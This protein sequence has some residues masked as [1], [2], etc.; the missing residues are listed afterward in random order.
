MRERMIDQDW[1]ALGKLGHFLKGSAA[2]IGLVKL[3]DSCYRIQILGS[4]ADA[5][6]DPQR[7]TLCGL[8]AQ[9]ERE[10]R[11]AQAYFEHIFRQ[12]F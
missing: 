3:S 6:S 9:V 8:V 11:Q 12:T 1:E 7:T 4:A 10:C 5:G 2:T